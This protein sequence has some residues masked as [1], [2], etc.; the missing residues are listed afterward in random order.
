MIVVMS[1]TVVDAQA[2]H[3]S[4]ID[5]VGNITNNPILLVIK[6]HADWCD[7][8]RVMG[9]VLTDL[10]NKLDGKSILFTELDITNNSKNTKN[11]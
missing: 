10:T 4:Q 6:F 8:C 7:S 11:Y 9:G 1:F 2:T 5:K 3:L